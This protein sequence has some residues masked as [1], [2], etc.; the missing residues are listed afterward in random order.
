MGAAPFP[1]WVHWVGKVLLTL[2]A[3]GAIIGAAVAPERGE[4]HDTTTITV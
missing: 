1:P 2:P 4:E 3:Q